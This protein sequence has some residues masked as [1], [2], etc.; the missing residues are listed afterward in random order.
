MK[1]SLVAIAGCGLFVFSM[2]ISADAPTIDPA[3]DEQHFGEPAKVLFWTPEQQV[4]G[5]RNMDKLS[6]TRE[7]AAGGKPYPLPKDEVDLGDVEI[8]NQDLAMTVN[9]YV[10]RQNVAG[11]IVVKVPLGILFGCQVSDV[12]AGWRGD[13][14]RL[15]QERR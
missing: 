15:H 13:K 2:P 11:L 8:I 5:Y 1:N 6:P 7:V 3:S 9:D 10:K 12:V 14:R 4:S